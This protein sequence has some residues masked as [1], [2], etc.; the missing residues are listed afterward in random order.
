[1]LQVDDWLTGE[2]RRTVRGETQSVKNAIGRLAVR[3]N[4]IFQS[5]K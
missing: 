5:F 3:K 1:M 2:R 4:F